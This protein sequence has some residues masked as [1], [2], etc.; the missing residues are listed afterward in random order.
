MTM[1]MEWNNNVMGSREVYREFGPQ[2]GLWILWEWF[3]SQAG[4]MM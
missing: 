2:S 1:G 3:E 4:V